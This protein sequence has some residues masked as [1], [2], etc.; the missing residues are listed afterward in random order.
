MKKSYLTCV[1]LLLLCLSININVHA[2]NLV[3]I[4]SLLVGSEY[5]YPPYCIV[6]SKGNASGFS[7]EL[8][9]SVLKLMN[10]EHHYKIASWAEVRSALENG[11]IDILPLVGRTAEREDLYDFTFPYLTMHGTIVLRT[12]GVTADSFEDLENKKVAVMRADNAEEYVTNQETEVDLVLTDTFEEALLLLSRGDVDAVILQKLVAHQIINS[13]NLENLHVN[14]QILQDFK[15]SFCFAV[16][17]GNRALLEK[18]NEGLAIVISNGTF[19]R[20][21]SEWFTPDGAQRKSGD[22]LI[23]GGDDNF[24]PFEY[25]DEDGNPAG[26]IVDLTRAIAEFMDLNIRIELGP[27]NEAYGKL[28]SGDV[29]LLQGIFYSQE[30]DKIFS[31][32]QAHSVVSNV[33]VTRE[34]SK[35]IDSLADLK[36]LDVFVV[37]KDVTH[38]YL[39]EEKV[40]ANIITEDSIKTIV[41]RLASGEGDCALLAQIPSNYWITKFEL[42]NLVFGTHSLLSPEYNYGVLEQNSNL[43]LPFQEGLSVLMANGQQQEIYS[44]WLGRYEADNIMSIWEMI[45]FNFIIIIPFLSIII[46][47]F[48]WFLSLQKLVQSRTKELQLSEQKLNGI[49]NNLSSF[50]Y[51]LD[52]T[53]NFLSVNETMI[54]NLG[55]QKEDLIGKPY[56]HQIFQDILDPS[57]LDAFF[58]DS[59]LK[60][61][62]LQDIPYLDK[63]H[64]ERWLHTSLERIEDKMFDQPVIIGN[65]TDI[66][67]KKRQDQD[68]IK[69]NKAIDQSSVSIVIT[70][71]DG[72]IEYVNKKACTMSG[73]SE[74]E[75][76]GEKTSIFQSRETDSSV[77]SELWATIKSG[78]EWQG[79]FLNRKKNGETYWEDAQISP[80][81][82]S[83]NQITNF[84]ASKQDITLLLKKNDENRKLHEQLFHKSKMDVVGQLAGGIAHDFNN[85]LSGIVSSAQ[86]IKSEPE[87][88]ND[89]NLKYLDI[90]LQSSDRAKDLVS[91]LLSFSRMNDLKLSPLDAHITIRDVVQILNKTMNKNIN[92]IT[93]LNSEDSK[94]LGNDTELHNCLLN[95]CI[96]SSQAMPAGGNLL[97]RTE[98]R[99]INEDNCQNPLFEITPGDYIILEITDTGIGIPKKNL[100]KIFEPF[101]TTKNKDEGAGLGLAAVY[102]SM[103]NHHGMIEVDSLQNKGTIF[104]L[105]FPI[106]QE[107]ET[108][109]KEISIESGNGFILFVDDEEMNRFLGRDVLKS[110]GYEVLLASS[111]SEAIDLYRENRQKI[112]LVLL[113]FMMPGMN[114]KE[115]FLKLREINAECKIILASGFYENK[116]ILE[117]RDMGLNGEIQK[118]YTIESL[119]ALLNR[120]L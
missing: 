109:V 26:Y 116:D 47:V 7:V 108:P 103:V 82:D 117:M 17:E 24:P 69:L 107:H 110:I 14:E 58:S 62:Q 94:I 71:W 27:W 33:V 46:I 85:V 84:I 104:R 59:S 41:L 30:R 97:I 12:G 51:V 34:G 87:M 65:S 11:D 43:L 53:G 83:N 44:K 18:L 88:L 52:S 99:F 101:F 55:V 75:L 42:N 79:R 60:N 40:D 37:E 78:N 76:I 32:S 21:R 6:D 77:Y 67:D 1:F 61:I 25:L 2:D 28:I 118:P 49:M 3:Q 5:S 102:G 38:S 98:N 15:Q 80:I 105:F 29:D 119:S 48:I 22:L 8:L 111:G 64:K 113:D 10:L 63:D 31:F 50:V 112:D 45:R 54:E 96:N 35:T 70:D 36:G 39:I 86:L 92:I 89:K 9:N 13:L 106:T 56:N 90:I 19:D 66:T 23:I 4:E 91:R 115:T 20:L 81:K 114:G 73:Y 100:D 68:L 93:E 16:T 74:N 95:L 120:V 57:E 72:T